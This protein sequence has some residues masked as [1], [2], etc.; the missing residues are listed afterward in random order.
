MRISFKIATAE[1][2]A[3]STRP[4]FGHWCYMVIK[5]I[6]SKK[7]INPLESVQRK[8]TKVF[9]PSHPHILN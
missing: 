7:D 2:S 8:A 3:K 4:I 6:I 1:S 9:K 5:C